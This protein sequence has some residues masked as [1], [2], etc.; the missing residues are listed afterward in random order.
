M[1]QLESSKVADCSRYSAILMVA[2]RSLLI[3]C[4][5][6][7]LGAQGAASATR[8]SETGG[9][10]SCQ[11]TSLICAGQGAKA[12]AEASNPTESSTPRH[13]NI[14]PTYIIAVQAQCE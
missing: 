8:Q 12:G 1:T 10:S 13:F 7:A 11:R 14:I 4:A 3:S 2:V 9:Y 6:S 5:M